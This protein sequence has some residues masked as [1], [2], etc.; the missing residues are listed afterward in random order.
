MNYRRWRPPP[1]VLTAGEDFFEPDVEAEIRLIAGERIFTIGSCFAR[2]VE[3]FLA[4]HFRIPSR[5]TRSEVPADIAAIDPSLT[6]NDVLWHRYNV[7]SIRNSLEWGLCPNH[8]A[9]DGRL[10]DLG[11]GR[12]VDPYAGCRAVLAAAD[13]ERVGA[14]I[15]AT[16]AEVSSCRVVIITLGLSEVWEDMDTG[17]VMNSA[18]LTELW[19]AFPGRFRFRVATCEETVLELEHLHALLSEHCPAGLQIV[20]TVSPIPLTA[21]FRELDIVVANAASKSILR[22][23]VDH[24]TREHDDV[25]YFPSYEIILNSSAAATWMEDYRHCKPETIGRA[26]DVFLTRFVTVERSSSSSPGAGSV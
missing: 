15:D 5:V 4:P 23:A 25:H 14:W 21:T 10:I 9:A 24:W 17:L 1:I 16:M 8:P 12:S 20:V 6:A 7:F 22:A 18:P 19:E 2:N 11:D 13:A 3:G 26:M